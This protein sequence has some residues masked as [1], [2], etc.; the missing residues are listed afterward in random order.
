GARHTSMAVNG[1]HEWASEHPVLIAYDVTVTPAD[2]RRARARGQRV[3]AVENHPHSL[4]RL[5]ELG[6]DGVVA[7]DSRRAVRLAGR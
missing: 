5:A 7:D 2:I 6:V 4:R 3:Y 1:Q